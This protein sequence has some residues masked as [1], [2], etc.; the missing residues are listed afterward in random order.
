MTDRETGLV[1]DNTE[2]LKYSTPFFCVG[3]EYSPRP[4]GVQVWFGRKNKRANDGRT[5]GWRVLR[6][7]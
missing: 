2:K 6:E 4:L 7:V 3:P 5:I 1:I